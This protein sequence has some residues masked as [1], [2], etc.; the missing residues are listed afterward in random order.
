[1][2]FPER[3][4]GTL[5]GVG[6]SLFNCGEW[7]SILKVDFLRTGTA[8]AVAVEVTLSI[9]IPI[10]IGSS[11][12]KIDTGVYSTSA[13]HVSDV[14][15]SARLSSAEKN[16][17]THGARAT[18]IT[19]ATSEV[20][21]STEE[22]GGVPAGVVTAG[23]FTAGVVPAGVVVSS[24][25]C[26]AAQCIA[27]TKLLNKA[28]TLLEMAANTAAVALTTMFLVLLMMVIVFCVELITKEEEKRRLLVCT[29]HLNMKLKR[30][31]E[32]CLT[33]S[34]SCSQ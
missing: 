34:K 1:M 15:F 6:H 32:Y 23:F 22:V 2:K 19:G 18:K 20:T 29:S 14:A 3:P 9:T 5:G 12:N 10:A 17:F 8:V 11:G 33:Y 21:M 16:S 26:S 7:T 25:A 27:P 31:A 28:L 30:E 4:R 24:I 13:V